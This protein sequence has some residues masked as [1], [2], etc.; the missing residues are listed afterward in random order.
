MTC[1]GLNS[2]HSFFVC[3]F[4]DWIF[5]FPV[6]Q[7]QPQKTNTFIHFFVDDVARKKRCIDKQ[8]KAKKCHKTNNWTHTDY[9]AIKK[10]YLNSLLLMQ[11]TNTI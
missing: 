4:I 11:E 10:S 8:H 6:L 7:I 5:I 1:H 9:R 3:H 2:T